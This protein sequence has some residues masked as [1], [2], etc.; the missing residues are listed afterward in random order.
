MSHDVGGAVVP[1]HQDAHMVV[2]A[3]RR[4]P[5]PAGRE[6]DAL[7]RGGVEAAAEGD[8]KRPGGRVGQG[9]Q[10]GGGTGEGRV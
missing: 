5:L 1:E 4:H 8:L 10:P 7:D 3:R 6:D 9:D 2:V